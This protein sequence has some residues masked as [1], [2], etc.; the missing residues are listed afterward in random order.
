M[1]Y[2]LITLH[3]HTR[4]GVLC[5]GL[6]SI[7]IC[8]YIYV[9]D[10]KKFEWHLAVDLPFQTLTVDFPLNL[11]IRSTTARSRNTFLIE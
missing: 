8:M 10:Q 2:L 4:A 6:V 7:Y 11:Y 3:V 5:L 1:I 9:Y